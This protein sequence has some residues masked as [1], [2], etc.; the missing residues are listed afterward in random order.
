MTNIEK[1]TARIN[2]CGNPIAVYQ[3]LLVF[4]EMSRKG[5]APHA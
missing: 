1:L 2:A 4:L 5:G 3:A